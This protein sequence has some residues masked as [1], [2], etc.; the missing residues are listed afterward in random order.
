MTSLIPKER[1]SR[2]D[3]EFNPDFV[4]VINVGIS[5]GYI[6]W[7]VNWAKVLTVEDNLQIFNVITTTKA[8]VWPAIYPPYPN[9]SKVIQPYI[10]RVWPPLNK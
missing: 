7:I 5:Q 10:I 4:R 1:N 3:I 2:L 8:E 6:N 9:I